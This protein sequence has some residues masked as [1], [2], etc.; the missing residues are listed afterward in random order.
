[1]GSTGSRATVNAVTY[2]GQK[3]ENLIVYPAS[4]GERED[5]GGE[6]RLRRGMLMMVMISEL[7]A[8]RWWR[9]IQ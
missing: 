9:D 6:T 1:M 3:L 4:K 5:L 2:G 8:R 7:F